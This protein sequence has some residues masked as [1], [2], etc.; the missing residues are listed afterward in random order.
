MPAIR[1]HDAQ[2]LRSRRVSIPNPLTLT[3]FLNQ[4][5]SSRG[6]EIVLLSRTGT[7]AVSGVATAV[8]ATDYITVA[9]DAAP[10]LH[11]HIG[12]HEAAHLILE[13]RGTLKTPTGLKNSTSGAGPIM[14]RA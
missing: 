2:R 1:G 13:H 10:L 12:L 9:N 7:S 5:A 11:R 8:G 14:S 4:L 6:R 3:G